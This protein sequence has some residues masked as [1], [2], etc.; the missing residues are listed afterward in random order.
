[1]LLGFAIGLMVAL[2]ELAF[3]KAWLEVRYGPREMVTVNLGP[4]PVKVGGDGRACAVF[5]RGAPPI[6]LRFWLREGKAYFEDV[7]TK[8]TAEAPLD[9]P[10]TVG[11]LSLTVRSALVAAPPPAATAKPA[12]PAPSKRGDS[13]PQCGAFVPYKPGQRECVCGHVF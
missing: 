8:M 9:R 6:A 7:P 5:A 3:R 4:E 13:C 1:V 10:L 11:S 2:V 12:Q